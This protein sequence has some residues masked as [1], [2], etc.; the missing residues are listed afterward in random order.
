MTAPVNKCL[1]HTPIPAHTGETTRGKCHLVSLNAN[2]RRPT[3]GINKGGKGNRPARRLMAIVIRVASTIF[4]R[5]A[6]TR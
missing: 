4:N 1:I 3:P 5:L 6:P 2:P